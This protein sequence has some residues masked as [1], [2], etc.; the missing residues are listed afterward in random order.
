[1]EIPVTCVE[2]GTTENVDP[3]KIHSLMDGKPD[4]RRKQWK[5]RWVENVGPQYICPAE[6]YLTD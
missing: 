2:C 3:E 5:I 6:D 4:G 1:M